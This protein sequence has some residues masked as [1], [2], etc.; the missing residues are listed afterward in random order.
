[1]RTIFD[2]KIGKL[3]IGRLYVLNKYNSKEKLIPFNIDSLIKWYPFNSNYSYYY[4]DV[5]G[6]T[7]LS[8]DSRLSKFDSYGISKVGR[9][10]NSGILLQD[11]LNLKCEQVEKDN[12]ALCDEINN[13]GYANF[14]NAS[15]D[16]DCIEDQIKDTLDGITKLSVDITKKYEQKHHTNPEIINNYFGISLGDSTDEEDY[17]YYLLGCSYTMLKLKRDILK[18][19]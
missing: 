1:M 13:L 18:N 4:S 16:L 5:H 3:Y 14:I 11:G 12:Y 19:R 15:D 17:N 6:V 2:E 9:Q 10:E 8:K 7:Y